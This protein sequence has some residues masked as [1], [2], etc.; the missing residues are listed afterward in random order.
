MND[1]SGG[2]G[3]PP[4]SRGPRPQYYIMNDQHEAIPVRDVIEW[5]KWF[6]SADRHVAQDEIDGHRVSTVFLGLDH[7]HSGEGPPI[8]FETMIFKENDM[9]DEYQTRCSTWEEAE[10]M[11]R[12][13]IAFVK[14][15]QQ[16][17]RAVE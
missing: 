10:I 3:G 13:A 12:E 14:G 5:G 11:H 15:G 8:L 4:W 17:E 6:E 9:S 16:N 1:M 2:P 7:N